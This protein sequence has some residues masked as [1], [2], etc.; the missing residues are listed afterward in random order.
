MLRDVS[1]PVGSARVLD[2][3]ALLGEPI[4]SVEPI[5]EDHL[6]A[7]LGAL[8]GVVE[9]ELSRVA[10]ARMDDVT[11][12]YVE[13]FAEDAAEGGM[14][15]LSMLSMRMARTNAAPP[16]SRRWPQKEASVLGSIR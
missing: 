9:L 4:V 7:L 13:M 14:G 8:L 10:P 1:K 3:L 5:T 2:A 6:P 16:R 15:Y 11:S 12:G